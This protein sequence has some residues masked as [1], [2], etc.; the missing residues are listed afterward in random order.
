M[1]QTQCELC[2]SSTHLTTH[3]IPNAPESAPSS[4]AVVCETCLNHLSKDPKNS[5]WA[6]SL[7]DQ[8]YLEDEQLD[9]ARAESQEDDANQ[10]TSE[11]RDS[12]GAVLNQGDSVTLIKDLDVKGANFTAK[13]GTLVKGINLTGDPGLVEGRVNG[14]Q[15]VLKTIFLKKA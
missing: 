2:G 1:T 7:L 15:I 14:T 13:R 3:E 5:N 8:I 10:S 11:T 4:S 12:N 6:L 9:W